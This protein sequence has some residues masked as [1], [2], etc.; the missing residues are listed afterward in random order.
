[1]INT[2]LKFSNFY[3]RHFELI[4]K[5]NVVLKSLLHQGLSEP[6]F[7]GDLVCKFKKIVG[8][9]DFSD[10]FKNIII[11]HKR[12]GYDLKVMCQSTCIVVNPITV[13]NLLKIIMWT[14][15]QLMYCTTSETDGE[16]GTV[17][18]A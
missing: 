1:M 17:K 12:I 6:E 14:E 2:F 18:H 10:Q 4:S 8:R 9:N 3:R 5:F 7:Y 13:D 15:Q 16:V 11:H